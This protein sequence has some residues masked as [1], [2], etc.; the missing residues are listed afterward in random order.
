MDLVDMA[1]QAIDGTKLQANAAK[2]RTYDT[3]GLQRLLER[4]DTVIEEL[5]KQNEAGDDPP[6]IHLP[7]KLRQAQLLRTEVKT[8]MERLAAENGL[9]RVNL[10]DGDA[11]L[12]KSRQ[13]IVAGY[14]VQTVVS[15][16]KVTETDKTGGMFITAV[17]AVQDAEDHH[18]L[19]NMLEQAKEMTGE[20]AT[21]T[22]ADAGYHSGANLAACA[23][24]KQTVAIPESQENRAKR[25]YHNDFSYDANTDGYTCPM[26]QTLKFLETRCVVKKVV[27][28]YGGLGAVCRLCSAF[29]VCTKNRYRGRELLIGQYDIL[30]RNHRD[31]MATPEAKTAYQRRKELSEPSFGIIKE[32]MGFRRFLLRGL[33][34]IKAE[35]VMLATAFN[36]R[37][38]YRAWRQRLNKTWKA[39]SAGACTCVSVLYLVFMGYS[40][41]EMSDNMVITC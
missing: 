3:K 21:I 6:P 33:E 16:S 14:N 4:T 32:Q 28:V 19:I 1:V 34:N 13:V 7:E 27:R 15:P 2:D 11:K 18:Q 22:L 5:E 23:E 24:R 20:K 25:P 35:I 9:E 31:W 10:T 39:W 12:V 36:L 30:L 38:L 29:G 26:G 40:D 8:A 17:D 37:S 41:V